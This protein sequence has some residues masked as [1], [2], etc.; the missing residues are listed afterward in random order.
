MQS[1]TLY[2]KQCLERNIEMKV[3]KSYFKYS[4]SFDLTEAI[5]K[6]KNIFLKKNINFTLKEKNLYDNLLFL[7]K[8]VV[9]K[10]T[11]LTRLEKDN[12]EAY[13][14]VFINLATMGAENFL[15]KILKLR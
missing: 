2:E 15:M 8:S 4:K 14:A 7:T 12:E 3:T 1:R 10:I 6:A 13:Y 11:E 9:L 5:E